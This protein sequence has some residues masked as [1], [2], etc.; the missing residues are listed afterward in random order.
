MST[1]LL[2]SPF[3][4]VLTAAELTCYYPDATV[5]TGHI[6]CNATASDTPNDASACCAGY[7]NS[8]CLANGLCWF[9]G[10]LSRGS[11]TDKNWAS[12]SCPQWCQE[13]IQGPNTV[14]GICNQTNPWNRTKK[15]F[16]EHISLPSSR[17]LAMRMARRL[18]DQFHA[19]S[20]WLLR[21]H[22]WQS[23]TECPKRNWIR[24]SKCQICCCQ[25]DNSPYLLRFP[26]LDTSA[27]YILRAHR[28][29]KSRYRRR[30]RC[31][32][33]ACGA[34]HFLSVRPM[35]TTKACKWL[36][37]NGSCVCALRTWWGWTSGP[38]SV[39]GDGCCGHQV[40]IDG[41]D[42]EVG[43]GRWARVG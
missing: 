1:A 5:A 6:P 17:H 28:R 12:S 41:A 9:D 21:H 37:G 4:L 29:R 2:L 13:G 22:P 40:G 35:A 31:R 25:P 43:N 18:Q 8:Y 15:H 39:D 33:V 32:F 27:S 14:F 20:I 24:R 16:H 19:A 7:G 36:D 30:R 23:A 11:C 10:I 3:L 26:G 42:S 38:A 34:P